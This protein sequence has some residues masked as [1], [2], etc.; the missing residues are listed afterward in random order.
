MAVTKILQIKRSHKEA[1]EYIMDFDKTNKEKSEQQQAIDYITNDLKTSEGELVSGYNCD[2]SFSVAE[3]AMTQELAREVKGNYRNVGGADIRA[4]HVIQSFS[5]EDNITPEEAHEIGK[6]LMQEM[7]GGKHEFVIATHIDK[8]HI[9]NHIVFNATSFYSH[10]KFRCVPYKTASQIRSISDKL[11]AEHGLSVLPEKLPLKNNYQQ[12][13]KYRTQTTYRVQIRKRMSF[14]L[15]RETNLESLV[16]HAQELGV[17][18]D[19]TGK[20][21]TYN[22]E[23]Q[24]RNTRDEKLSDDG[25]FTKDG[26][27]E[28]LKQNEMLISRTENSILETFEKS[29]SIEDFER[30]LKNEFSISYK[31]NRKGEVQFEFLDTENLKL[32]ERVLNQGLTIDKI[33]EQLRKGMPLVREEL[34]IPLKEVYEEQAQTAVSEIDSPV[35]LDDSMIEKIT[36]EGLLIRADNGTGQTGH[37]FID[38]NHVD[39]LPKE[40]KYQIHLGDQF[41]YY[42]MENGKQTNFFLKGEMLL[43]QL[44]TKLEIP[45]HTIEISAKNIQSISEKG[46]SLNFESHGISRFFLPKEFV[47]YNKMSKKVSIELSNNWNYYYQK[48]QSNNSK[49][50]I[51]YEP[52]K[53]KDLIKVIE[54]QSPMLDDHLKYKLNNLD[55][56]LSIKHTKELAENLS[57]L[58]KNKVKDIP[59]LMKTIDELMSQVDST[60]VSI[61]SLE[62]KIGEYNT[63]AKFLIT[64]QKYYDTYV[65]VEQSGFQKNSLSMKFKDELKAFEVSK[66]ELEKRGISPNVDSNKVIELVK[67][68]HTQEKVLQ[69][70]LTSQE[71]NLTRYLQVKELLVELNKVPQKEQEKKKQHAKRE[72]LER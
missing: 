35:L 63:V 25:R 16:S 46:V 44:E 27:N 6:K 12:Y 29:L 56:R 51:P 10:T 67:E 59:G 71:T 17:T 50:K 32:N 19:L 65:S 3:F 31:R 70:Q 69:E 72:D 45:R 30:I 34:T 47:H 8:E 26:L 49:K 68:N 18:M 39:F 33:T 23:A 66:N 42:F 2:P 28:R 7:L 64:Y 11:C 48:E 5:P 43:R 54:D 24:K 22:F 40:K 58:R 60:R 37:I 62:E 9:H 13:Q 4:H 21:V 20:H 15:E 53:G 55:R 61:K 41:N 52:I 1:L 36:K 14:L 57:L 38:A